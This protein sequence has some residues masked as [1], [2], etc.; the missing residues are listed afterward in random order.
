MN[1]AAVAIIALGHS[2]NTSPNLIGLNCV[3]LCFADSSQITCSQIR[4]IKFIKK[5]YYKS[6]I[7]TWRP[8][9]PQS[10]ITSLVPDVV[11]YG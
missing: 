9:V 4:T 5:G 1:F 8:M 11:L 6:I 3:I 2:F 10:H 7:I